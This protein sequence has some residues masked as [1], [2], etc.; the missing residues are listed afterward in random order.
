MP[1]PRRGI[2]PGWTSLASQYMMDS[3]D[4]VEDV[5]IRWADYLDSDE[6]LA[7]ISPITL[8]DDGQGKRNLPC[9]IFTFTYLLI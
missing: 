1:L 6:F 3:M 4:E 8:F 2:S 5:I 9:P 7:A